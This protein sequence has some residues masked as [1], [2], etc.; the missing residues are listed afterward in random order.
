MRKLRETYLLY[1]QMIK[2]GE[3][4][5][6]FGLRQSAGFTLTCFQKVMALVIQ[7]QRTKNGL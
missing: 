7:I 2:L 5:S 3:Q 1:I 6:R 4:K